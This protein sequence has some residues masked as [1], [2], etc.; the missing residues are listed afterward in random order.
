MADTG[1]PEPQI[2][3]NSPSIQSNNSPPHNFT[4]SQL[5]KAIIKSSEQRV[6]QILISSPH[7]L[8]KSPECCLLYACLHDHHSIVKFILAMPCLKG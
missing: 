2:T 3:A 5:K 8:N 4:A 7:L 6:Q 1:S